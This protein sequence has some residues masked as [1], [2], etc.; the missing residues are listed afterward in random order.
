MALPYVPRHK[1]A[2]LERRRP[3]RVLTF[4]QDSLDRIRPS[5]KDK[6]SCAPRSTAARGA[7][8]PRLSGTLGK[9]LLSG[10]ARFPAGP[11]AIYRTFS[12]L[13]HHPLLLMQVL[14]RSRILRP[15]YRVCTGHL[16]SEPDAVGASPHQS[17]RGSE[18]S[19]AVADHTESNRRKTTSHPCGAKGW[20]PPGPALTSGS[21][22]CRPG[23][24]VT[25]P[26]FQH[27]LQGVIMELSRPDI[28]GPR[29]V[30]RERRDPPLH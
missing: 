21:R 28:R 18:T 29:Q 27:P 6:A 14:Y 23:S 15:G 9:S 17:H 11:S 2:S 3:G 24:A 4:S 25:R 22:G 19:P 30:Q 12:S 10:V 13:I 5:S 26:L 20:A 1:A 7:V 8:R 16:G